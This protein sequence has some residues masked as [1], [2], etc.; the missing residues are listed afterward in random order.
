M[1]KYVS[2]EQDYAQN[3]TLYFYPSPMFL[4]NFQKFKREHTFILCSGLRMDYS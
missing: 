2:L 4:L 3:L 1:P